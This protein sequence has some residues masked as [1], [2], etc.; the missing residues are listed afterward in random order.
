MRKRIIEAEE[1]KTIVAIL[2]DRICPD[3]RKF[4][5]VVDGIAG[6][7]KSGL[8]RYLAWKL[9]MPCIETDM[10]RIEQGV[11]H[12]RY[13]I[14]ELKTVIKSRHDLNLPVILEGDF[15]LRTME[16]IGIEPDFLIY[17]KNKWADCGDT[18]RES[19]PG[20]LEDYKPEKR[21]HFIF[22]TDNFIN[23]KRNGK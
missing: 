18:L 16:Q 6:V 23:V 12:P 8:G 17:V 13:R 2:R 20:Y 22:F 1:H 9:D 14:S 7:G 5:I 15:I 11:T 21:A 19:L 10:Y 3:W 4:T